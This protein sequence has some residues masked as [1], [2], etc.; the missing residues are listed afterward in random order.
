MPK[1]KTVKVSFQERYTYSFVCPHCRRSNVT[2]TVA[3]RN[4]LQ[5]DFCGT[6]IGR[7]S[8]S[9]EW[10]TVKELADSHSSPSFLE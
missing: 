4:A 6:I 1:I 10:S 7:W 5:C 3:V 8:D 2:V 9:D